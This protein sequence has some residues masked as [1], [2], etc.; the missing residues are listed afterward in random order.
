MSAQQFFFFLG[1][2]DIQ[3]VPLIAYKGGTR[4]QMFSSRTGLFMMFAWIKIKNERPVKSF[5]VFLHLAN[6]LSCIAKWE[7]WACALFPSVLYPFCLH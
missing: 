5:T 4:V 2:T 6:N 3:G 1:L 7:I